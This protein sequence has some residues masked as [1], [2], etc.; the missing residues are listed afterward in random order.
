MDPSED[1]IAR[2]P[3]LEVSRPGDGLS[4]IARGGLLRGISIASAILL[5]FPATII[6]VRALGI[7]D[8]G[9]FAFAIGIASLAGT[10]SD[11]GVDS[12]VIRMI[13]FAGG[14]SG[15]RWGRVAVRIGLVGGTIALLACWAIG[16]FLLSGQARVALLILGPMALSAGVRGTLG[17]LLI[18]YRRMRIVE[19]TVIAQTVLYYGTTILLGALGLATVARVASAQVIAAWIAVLALVPAWRRIVRGSESGPTGEETA[20]RLIAF[21]IPILIQGVALIA[22]QRSDVVLLGAMKGTHAVGLYVPALRL[23]DVTAV[24]LSSVIAYYVP[25]IAPM[26]AA[27]EWTRV[28]SMYTI[29]AKWGLVLLGPILAALIIAPLPILVLMFGRELGPAE[30]V[31]RVLAIGYMVNLLAGHNSATLLA[32][33]K[34]KEIGI[35][36]VVALVVNIGVNAV[37]IPRYGALGAALG[38]SIVYTG[39]NVANSILIYRAAGIHPFRRD[40]L[41]LLGTWAGSGLVAFGAVSA[42]GWRDSFGGAVAI[43]A[44]VGL[45]TL[46]VFVV[47]ADPEE[48]VLL[49]ALGRRL[50][51][52]PAGPG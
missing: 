41:T 3:E 25:V 11:L 5:S 13:S 50:H 43:G 28:R 21:S 27:R 22:L 16:A 32:L 6:L 19:G 42:L 51:L 40:Y 17:G 18:A 45:A 52:F 35:R 23:T 34:T 12:G 26:I 44:L 36:S 37:L 8:Y 38:T 15:I 10:L 39:L 33:G 30:N 49:R 2:T 4:S 47:T 1:A 31:T 14:A 20:R 7:G 24:V 48:R 46:A 9:A 29:L